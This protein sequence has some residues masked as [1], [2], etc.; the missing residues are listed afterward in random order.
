MAW[1][2]LHQNLPAH[3]K[4]KKLKRLLKI[5][6]P[7][8]IGHL[9]ML[10]LWAVDNTPDGDLSM[11][12]PEDIAEACE[13]T[14]GAND[15]VDAL[16]EAGFIDPD[17]KLH[18]WNDYV[19]ML[20]D[21]RENQREQNRK[22]QQR[23]RDKQ[24]AV[25]SARSENPVMRDNNVSVTRYGSVNNATVTPL[26]N[27][28]EPNQTE[29]NHND[30]YEEDKNVLPM[31]EG[32]AASRPCLHGK[33]SESVAYYC[34]HINATPSVLSLSQLE[35]FETEMGTAVC[36]RAMEIALDEKAARWTYIRG[37]LRNWSGQGVK[38]IADVQAL[39]EKHQVSTLQQ[40]GAGKGPKA[41]APAA[42][43]PVSHAEKEQEI[44]EN[45]RWMREF[46]DE[47][48]AEET[49]KNAD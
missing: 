27:Q 34:Q 25:G 49:K 17:D 28:T 35:A 4:V 12:D 47:S 43:A 41:P 16:M 15:F 14:K 24:K 33:R 13:W 40:R 37:I 9:A 3:R 20:I 30:K 36:I 11:L 21:R 8:A 26:P 18:D 46:L 22:R 39:D 10:W 45:E 32:A 31:A 38:C 23:Y 48:K 6:T 42:Q 44:L 19:G 2:E 5:K 1:I 29:P 7:Q